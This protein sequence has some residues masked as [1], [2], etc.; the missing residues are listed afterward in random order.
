MSCFALADRSVVEEGLRRLS[1]DLDSGVWA[2]RYGS[3]LG[4]EEFDAGTGS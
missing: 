1:R 2:K 3:V 4:L